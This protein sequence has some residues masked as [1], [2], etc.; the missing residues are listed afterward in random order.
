MKKLVLA[1]ALF[2]PVTVLVSCSETQTETKT[3]TIIIRETEATTEE[4]KG[5]LERAAVKVD[6]E[7]NKKIDNQIDK[8][9]T[10]D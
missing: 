2:L 3:E 9:G 8:I 10:D 7:V 1:L 6:D 4:N 5:A